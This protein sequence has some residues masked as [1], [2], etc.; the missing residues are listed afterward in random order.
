MKK[1][2]ISQ[3]QFNGLVADICRQVVNSSWKPDYVVGI[4]R[5]G[6][7]AAVMISH[8]FNCSC[9]MLKV[10]FADDDQQESNCWMSE[11]AFGYESTPKNIL[12]VDDINDTG[13]T[14]NWIVDDWQ[15]T[16][17]PNHEQWKSVWN[18]NVRFATVVDNTASKFAHKI[19]FAGMEIN[20]VE[21]PAWIVFPY[22]NWWVDYAD[23][24]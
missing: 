1:H 17:L 20:K 24:L 2:F 9:E 15:S 4:T 12:I 10:S 16:C 21:D 3:K 6:S 5:G 11:D 22:E 19:D 14:L 8:Y 7:I 18:N 13:R 23:H